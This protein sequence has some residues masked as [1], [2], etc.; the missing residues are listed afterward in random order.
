MY[1]LRVMVCIALTE[2]LLLLIIH[3]WPVEI[4]GNSSRDI[5][6]NEGRILIEQVVITQQQSA[7]PPPTKPQIPIPVPNDQVIEEEIIILQDFDI[8]QY[9]DSLFVGKGGA[10]G[11][12]DRV[13]KNPQKSPSIIRIV[14]PTVPDAAQKAGVKAQIWVNLLIDKR[15]DVVEANI[16]KILL[17]DEETE[18]FRQVPRIDYGLT[19]ATI[20]AALQWEF[21]PATDNGQPVKAYSEQIFSFGF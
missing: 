14:E 8:S 3:F 1:R 21:R 20:N 12:A 10:A 17:Y 2:V 19:E 11:N 13:V 6:F 16:S 15:G 4:T 5:D 9:A 7:P 18:D